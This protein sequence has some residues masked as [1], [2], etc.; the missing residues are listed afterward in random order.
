MDYNGPSV[1]VQNKAIWQTPSQLHIP[2][3]WMYTGDVIW[4]FYFFPHF[5]TMFLFEVDNWVRLEELKS[6]KGQR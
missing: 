2:S 3:T 6:Y 5:L 4:A 1:S